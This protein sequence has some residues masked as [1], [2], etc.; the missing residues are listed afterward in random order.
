M[1]IFCNIEIHESIEKTLLM[2]IKNYLLD[3]NSFISLDDAETL[4]GCEKI[5]KLEFNPYCFQ[6]NAFSSLM[7]QLINTL[8]EQ[9]MF[10]TRVEICE[11]FVEFFKPFIIDTYA[12][13]EFQNHPTSHLLS[14]KDRENFYNECKQNI[15]HDVKS[16]LNLLRESF[17]NNI[18]L[19]FDDAY[20][21]IQKKIFIFNTIKLLKSFTIFNKFFEDNYSH[22]ISKLF[23]A[24]RKTSFKTLLKKLNTL[25][26]NEIG[27]HP[28][29]GIHYVHI[30]NII[31]S[32]Y[33][34]KHKRALVEPQLKSLK[35]LINQNTIM[36]ITHVQYDMAKFSTF[37][38]KDQIPYYVS[39]YYFSKV[40]NLDYKKHFD[41]IR[42]LFAFLLSKET[43]KLFN[44]RINFD[45]VPEPCSFTFYD[46]FYIEDEKNH[47][48]RVWQI[49][50]EEH[51]FDKF[52]HLVSK[53]DY[54]DDEFEY[55]QLPVK[56]KKKSKKS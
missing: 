27:Y 8:Y 17:E 39:H 18:L 15:D 41:D 10:L 52:E 7:K 26:I 49:Q 36:N 32:I 48:P 54:W 23:W 9:T 2:L 35:D 56:I 25:N 31:Y 12:L 6:I 3:V 40:V 29:V 11:K 50:S 45:D 22:C 20:S 14:L 38:N 21:E 13:L 51:R 30:V 53:S 24:T 33:L 42:K 44:T 5:L 16:S 4:E 19:E 37:I 46:Y 47:F 1:K 43:Y 34:I 28:L 55:S